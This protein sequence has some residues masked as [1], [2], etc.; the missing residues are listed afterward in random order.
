MMTSKTANNNPGLCPNKGHSG[1]DAK[2]VRPNCEKGK[3][4]EC[5]FCVKSE[6]PL[7]MEIQNFDNIHF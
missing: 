2:A 4:A 3:G 7:F 1:G 5:H 6:H